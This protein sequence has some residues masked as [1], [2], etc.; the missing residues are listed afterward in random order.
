[1]GRAAGITEEQLRDLPVYKDSTAFSA[2]GKLVIEYA[3]EMTKTPVGVP[4]ALFA[5]LRREFN[6]AQL[7]ELTTAIAWENF[8]ARFDHALG[9][10]SQ[11]FL[12]RRLLPA[13]GY[14]ERL[15]SKQ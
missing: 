2:L 11:G 9:I 1:M 15:I 3:V 14:C 6:E 13:P 8:R 12:R 5:A 7:V 4:E 10:E